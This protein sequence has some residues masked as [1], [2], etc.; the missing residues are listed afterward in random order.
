MCAALVSLEICTAQQAFATSYSFSIFDAPGYTNAT[1][2]LGIN[3]SGQVVGTVGNGQFGTYPD[4]HA[5][6]KDGSSYTFFDVPGSGTT[7]EPHGINSTGQVV[8]L[9]VDTTPSRLGF[10]KDGT[11]YTAISVPGGTGY[12]EANDINNVG[13]IVGSFFDTAGIRQGFQKDGEV[14]TTLKVPGAVSTV[15]N[16]I[17]DGGEVVG[18][19]SRGAFLKSGETYTSLIVPGY[20]SSST[21]AFG[22]NDTDVIVGQVTDGSYYHGFVKDASGYTIF[23]VPGAVDTFPRGI[24]SS[25]QIVGYLDESDGAVHGFVA[26]PVPEPAPLDLLGT[27]LGLLTWRARRRH[28]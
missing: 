26:T 6:V 12:N 2:A 14:Y 19:S 22:I 24:N 13:Q 27:G 28:A 25:G 23:D 15:P 17:N 1:V 9:Y 18:S 3:D 20:L 7:T 11:T 4:V 8:G 10:L 21:F 5:F 16:G